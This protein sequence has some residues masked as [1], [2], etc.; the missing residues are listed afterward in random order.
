MLALSVVDMGHTAAF[1]SL[2][3]AAYQLGRIPGSALGGA[4]AHRL[5]AAGAAM[6]SLAILA[7]G[8]AV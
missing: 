4:L 1:A 2:A 5:G 7:V 6:L 8:A 3:V